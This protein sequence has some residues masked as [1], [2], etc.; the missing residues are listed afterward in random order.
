MYVTDFLSSRSDPFEISPGMWNDD[1][2][3][4]QYGSIRRFSLGESLVREK[5][6]RRPRRVG[7]RARRKF[8]FSRRVMYYASSLSNPFQEPRI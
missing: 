3:A 2:I 8:S 1:G 6:A 4:A 5:L 7:K